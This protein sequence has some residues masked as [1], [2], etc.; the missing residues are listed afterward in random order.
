MKAAKWVL[1]VL[2][3]T[4]ILVFI[5]CF[6][7]LQS[8][9]QKSYLNTLPE[10][11]GKTVTYL[12]I[13]GL[14]KT[15]FEEQLSKGNLPYIKQL[16][17]SGTYVRNGI[18]SFPS[19]TGYGFYPFLTGIDAT[20]SGVIGLRWFDRT[21]TEGN[22]RNYVGRSNIHMNLDVT[23][24]YKGVFEYFSES[25]TSSIN[26]YMNKGVHHNQKTGWEMTSAKYYKKPL[27]KF[28]RSVPYF[29]NRITYN[30][31]DHETYV[32]GLAMDQLQ[33]NPKVQWVTFASPDASHHISGTTEDYPKILQHIDGLVGNIRNKVKELGQ[34]NDRMIV[35][36]SDHGNSEVKVNLDLRVNF[37]E[38]LGLELER[39]E[40]TVLMTSE[41]NSPF[42]EFAD[43][44]GYLVINGNLSAYL[45]MKDQ[46]ENAWSSR[47]SYDQIT[48]YSNGEK[49]IDLPD[50]ISNIQ[51]VELVSY[52]FNDS[53]I[54]VQ[55][56]FGKG[57]ISTNTQGKYKYV[58]TDTDPLG[59]KNDS[60]VFKLMDDQFHSAKM[61]LE[62]SIQTNYPDALHR[63]YSLVSKPDM[64]DILICT[65]ENY[66]LAKDYEMLIGNYKGG[67]GGIR[68]EMLNVPYVLYA[69]GQNSQVVPFSRS[70]DVGATVLEYLDMNTEYELDGKSLFQSADN[71]NN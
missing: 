13:D 12:L 66:D 68:A 60:T 32:A 17:N 48:H 64:G 15:I 25:Y 36:I 43:K 51:G 52:I 34:E 41:L 39:G 58:V 49:Q 46:E 38:D 44:D 7:I 47:L 30:Y 1:L 67:H 19:M 31:F 69:P 59:Y 35:L 54:I 2:G 3:A 10:T 24:E 4:I 5:L 62:A 45:Y 33:H 23:Q 27:F 61:W 65:L 70:E 40:S 28:L 16:I 6:A 53:T 57:T 14:S 63:L 37:E 42:E 26:S 11:T 29:G 8:T 22:L 71:I 50:Y 56:K 9:K 55:N 18:S 20:K 21:R